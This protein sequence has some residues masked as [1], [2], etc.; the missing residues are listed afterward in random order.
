MLQ[1]SLE[2]GRTRV[3][4]RH[5][6]RDAPEPHRRRA[7]RA[8]HGAR[9]VRRP[10]L[11]DGLH[12]RSSRS[13]P[14]SGADVTIAVRRRADRGGVARSASSRST[15]RTGSSSGRRSRRS[16]ERPRVDGRLRVPKRALVALAGRRPPRLRRGRHPGDARRR[17]PR[18]YGYRS[19]ATGRTSARS[20]RTGRPTWRSS[21]TTRSSTC[22]TRTGSSTPGPRSGRRPRWARRR[23]ST[24][25]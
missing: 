12:S 11:Q 8:G 19:R 13:T 4:P 24:G 2:R 16:P 25:R 20:S 7:R 6:R 18:V 21:T 23:R 5:R 17:G 1:P 22:T 10:H 15:T 14:A 9:P 3:V